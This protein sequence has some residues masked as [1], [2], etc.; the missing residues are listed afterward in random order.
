[1]KIIKYKFFKAPKDFEIWQLYKE[2]KIHQ[3][4]PVVQSMDVKSN[5][6]NSTSKITAGCF[7]TYFSEVNDGDT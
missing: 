4:T 3:I 2:R 5:G 6:N 1:M 7:V